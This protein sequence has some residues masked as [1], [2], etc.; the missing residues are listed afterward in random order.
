[1]EEI[2]AWAL[3]LRELIVA[4]EDLRKAVAACAGL[5]VAEV[6]ALGEV[7]RYGPR[8]PSQLITR[9]GMTS[10]SVT[11]LLNRLQSAGLITRTAHPMDGR[12]L[13]VELSPA[14]TELIQTLLESV[15]ADVATAAGVDQS[16][17]LA[18]LTALM[19]QVSI[20]L[21][22]RAADRDS[23]T[24]T[25]SRGRQTGAEPTGS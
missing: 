2:T 14:G 19:D 21:R 16:E 13:F 5:G 18:E 20:A 15:A 12:K 7:W 10:A 9:L 17:R 1:M 22:T 25:L 11:A 8:M 3:R 23:I 4:A 24:E 6:V